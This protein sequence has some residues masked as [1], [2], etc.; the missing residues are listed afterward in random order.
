LHNQ[1]LTLWGPAEVRPPIAIF[2]A[3]LLAQKVDALTVVHLDI[4]AEVSST[5]VISLFESKHCL[6]SNS[7]GA[8]MT[9]TVH[10]NLFVKT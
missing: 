9:K 10:N 2:V 4:F 8:K 5:K 7:S 6:F 3:F 1:Y